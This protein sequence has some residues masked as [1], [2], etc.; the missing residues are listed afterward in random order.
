MDM[1][2]DIVVPDP[3]AQTLADFAERHATAWAFEQASV[4]AASRLIL[5]LQRAT[6]TAVLAAQSSWLAATSKLLDS[7]AN[8]SSNLYAA[9]TTAANEFGALGD[10]P[11]E[12]AAV[13]HHASGADGL[14]TYNVSTNWK[15]TMAI[16]LGLD[17][18]DP[19]VY[20]DPGSPVYLAW[21]DQVGNAGT[22]ID[23]TM[24]V[25][26]SLVNTADSWSWW[27]PDSRL[28]IASSHSREQGNADY[29]TVCQIV[30][31][32]PDWYPWGLVGFTYRPPADTLRKR[33]EPYDGAN[34]LW[35][36]RPANE[37]ARTGGEAIEVLI[38][39]EISIAQLDGIP[40]W[41]PT[42]SILAVIQKAPGVNDYADDL[43][44]AWQGVETEDQQRV[45]FWQTTV[46]EQ[47]R[48][49]RA[50][51]DAVFNQQA[52]NRVRG[53]QTHE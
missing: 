27:S 32:A 39:S 7:S 51:S 14:Y 12:A 5:E 8:P 29:F 42:Q 40:A 6:T 34:P 45:A 50:K 16:A 36:Q 15:R 38:G 53:A 2:S 30:S 22:P 23:P 35:V 17:P 44:I 26:T 37:S 21:A 48:T 1:S 3:D 20:A 18:N 41:M 28:D 11:R 47:C 31:L 4:S 33:P 19:K 43:L 9:M 25:G 10:T 52:A 46:V 49:S 24:L 13:L